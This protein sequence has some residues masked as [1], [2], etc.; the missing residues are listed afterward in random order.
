MAVNLSD[1]NLDQ[2]QILAATIQTRREVI[3]GYQSTIDQT[4]TAQDAE[5]AQLVIDKQALKDLIIAMT[6]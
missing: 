2:M 1:A 5:K 6:A 3:N 4:K